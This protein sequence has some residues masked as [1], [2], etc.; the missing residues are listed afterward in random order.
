MWNRIAQFIVR[1]PRLIDWMISRASRN[2]YTH[3]VNSAGEVYMRRFWLF[4]SFNSRWHIKW[5]PSIRMHHILLPDEG[6]HMHDHPW[7]F[8]TII[9]RGWY[10]EEKGR[11]FPTYS[12]HTAGSTLKRSRDDFHR[13]SAV[14]DGGA[15]TLFVITSPRENEWGFW[16]GDTKVPWRQYLASKSDPSPTAQKEHEG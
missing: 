6:P 15:W 8:R 12:I 10:A 13:I 14:A 4:N 2:P 16:T 5:L 9:L 3:I 1:R 7:D 11:F